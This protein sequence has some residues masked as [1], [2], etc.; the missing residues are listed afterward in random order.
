M[1]DL[2]SI[3]PANVISVYMDRLTRANHDIIVRTA[4]QLETEQRIDELK[5]QLAESFKHAEDL[6]FELA[7][8]HDEIAKLTRA[9]S[10]NGDRELAKIEVLP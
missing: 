1:D 10:I 3:N 6:Q 4:L 8:A 7:E 9:L 5:R 2:T